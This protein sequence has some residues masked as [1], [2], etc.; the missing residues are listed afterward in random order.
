MPTMTRD[1]WTVLVGL[2]FI[3]CKK[4]D[5]P[6]PKPA[7]VKADE[8]KAEPV[9][10][11]AP[12]DDSAAIA[13]R[14]KVRVTLDDLGLSI[15][16]PEGTKPTPQS[17]DRKQRAAHVETGKGGFMVNINA[18]DEYSTPSFEKAIEVYKDDKL[19]EWIE[20]GQTQ[21][22]WITFKQVISSLHKGPRFEVEVRT[23]VNSKRWD[24]GVSAPNRGYAELALAACQ[25]LQIAGASK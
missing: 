15:E 1:L 5:A 13:A 21:T 2:A 8:A 9:A 6:A 23:L 14:P 20:K 10:K 3:A 16:V 18:V 7:D 4:D 22:G 24:C 17:A 25:S 11:E 12:P 19:V